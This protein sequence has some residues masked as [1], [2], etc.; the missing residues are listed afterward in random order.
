MACWRNIHYCQDAAAQG[1]VSRQ[2]MSP[3]A[4]VVDVLSFGE[5][6]SVTATHADGNDLWLELE[7]GSFVL[8]RGAG[9][10]NCVDMGHWMRTRG[11]IPEGAIYGQNFPEKMQ[12]EGY[13]GSANI[14]VVSAPG[15]AFWREVNIEMLCRD[16]ASATLFSQELEGDHV[17]SEWVAH[18]AMN[19]STH[20]AG[21]KRFVALVKPTSEWQTFRDGCKGVPMEQLKPNLRMNQEKELQWVQKVANKLNQKW[22]E[23]EFIT[24]FVFLRKYC[25]WTEADCRAVANLKLM[26][27]A[28]GFDGMEPEQCVHELQSAFW[29][30]MEAFDAEP[31]ASKE[32]AA[33]CCSCLRSLAQQSTRPSL[34]IT[35]AGDQ[36]DGWSLLRQQLQVQAPQQIMDFASEPLVF[37]LSALRREL[38]DLR[39]E[40]AAASAAEVAA[41]VAALKAKNEEQAKRIEELEGLRRKQVERIRELEAGVGRQAPEE[42]TCVI[43][44]G[45]DKTAQMWSIKSGKLV[46]TFEGHTAQIW[47]CCLSSDK[48]H[49]FTTSQDGT[50]K[51]WSVETGKVVRSF[52]GQSGQPNWAAVTPDMKYLVT[53][54]N[55]C[56]AKVWEVATGV[57]KQSLRHGDC[58]CSVCISKDGKYL[59]SASDDGLGRKWEIPSFKE[60]CRFDGKNRGGLYSCFLSA[61]GRHFF[62]A[63]HDGTARMFD[64]AKGGEALFRFEGAGGA[65][66]ICSSPTAPYVFVGRDDTGGSIVQMF[67]TET[68]VLKRTFKGHARGVSAMMVTPDGSF[69]LTAS[70]DGTAKVWDVSTG[71]AVVTYKGH[72]GLLQGIT[73]L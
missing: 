27:I 45:G 50:A 55:D 10:V 23:V 13:G 66:N 22:S 60:V 2:G 34:Q 38:E 62:T 47:S 42:A 54:V 72:K 52:S 63:S 3:G 31:M 36:S 61:D 11:Q 16:I 1:L 18:Y 24:V 68:G 39:Q 53:A 41:E 49:L 56:T 64:A 7:S 70:W 8:A 12:T 58:V 48:K 73:C 9:V 69:L 25:T 67:S 21:G 14:V 32:S 46:R 37:C 19:L 28:R 40:R 4:A 57:F 5:R 20:G 6:L 65:S 26:Q 43:T 44:A 29:L 59:Y 35:L 71:E 15:D 17:F 30:W 51:H 33:T